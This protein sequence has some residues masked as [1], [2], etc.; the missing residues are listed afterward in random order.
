MT[1]R[2]INDDALLKNGGRK[3]VSIQQSDLAHLMY[4]LGEKFFHEE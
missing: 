4:K 2:F 3:A 1:T